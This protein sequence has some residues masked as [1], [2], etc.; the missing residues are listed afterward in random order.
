[1]AIPNGPWIVVDRPQKTKTAKKDNR[2]KLR[3]MVPI[4][5]VERVSE[6]IKRINLKH[7]MFMIH[8][9]NQLYILR[10]LPS[11]AD[12]PGKAVNR[13]TCSSESKHL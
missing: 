13:S 8:C 4:P 12:F 5:Y 10:R 9:L 3:G 6:K 1:M 2:N 11:S 7:G